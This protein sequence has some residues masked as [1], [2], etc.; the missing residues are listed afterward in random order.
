M[1]TGEPRAARPQPVGGDGGGGFR[2]DGTGDGWGKGAVA[3][4]RCGGPI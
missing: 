2:Q 1:E 3:G 4:R